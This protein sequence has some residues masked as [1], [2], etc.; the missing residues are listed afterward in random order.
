MSDTADQDKEVDF[1]SVYQDQSKS[2]V[3]LPWDIGAAQPSVVA[4]EKAGGF[5]GEVLDIGC[6]LGDNALHLA[7]LGYRVTGLDASAWAIGQARIRA[8]VKGVSVDFDVADALDLS[9][10]HGRFDTV[11][12][13]A[14]YHC[15]PTKTRPAYVAAVAQATKPGS[16]LHI[17]SFSDRLPESF[18]VRVGERELRE[19]LTGAWD[20]V[21]L[22]LTHFDTSVTRAGLRAN[23]R[24]MVPEE[25]L[26][27]EVFADLET[28]GHDRVRI[29]V[30]Q[31]TAERR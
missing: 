18:P 28:D 26:G 21:S 4:L 27:A 16:L 3:S 13:S 5:H 11:L 20:I 19:N 24:V 25:E 29:P 9:A 30:W 15:L 12:D 23:V 7:G 8:A 17:F 2:G 31:V 22:R 10:Y 6:G 1:D 14:L